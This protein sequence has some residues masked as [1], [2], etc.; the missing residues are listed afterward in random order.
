MDEN[1]EYDAVAR[2]EAEDAWFEDEEPSWEDEMDQ[3]SQKEGE[4]GIQDF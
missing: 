4:T 1:E 2:R 3:R